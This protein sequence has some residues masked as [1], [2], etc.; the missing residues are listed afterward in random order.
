MSQ[1]KE[2]LKK[3]KNEL[4]T[5]TVAATKDRKLSPKEIKELADTQAKIDIIE[6]VITGGNN[7]TK[8]MK[9][10]YDNIVERYETVKQ[11]NVQI[12]QQREAVEQA[13]EQGNYYEYDQ[14]DI[15][16]AIMLFGKA[17]AAV[18]ATEQLV[19][20]YGKPSINNLDNPVPIYKAMKILLRGMQ[21][22]GKALKQ[23]RLGFPNQQNKAERLIGPWEKKVYALIRKHETE[24]DSAKRTENWNTIQELLKAGDQLKGDL[25]KNESLKDKEKTAA[26]TQI[27]TQQ[28]RL[29]KLAKGLEK[30]MVNFKDGDNEQGNFVPSMKHGLVN[31][32]EKADTTIRQCYRFKQTWSDYIN[33]LCSN[34]NEAL[35]V[36]KTLESNEKELDTEIS[37]AI[38]SFTG[39]LTGNLFSLASGKLATM[40]IKCNEQIVSVGDLLAKT[41]NEFLDTKTKGLLN[42]VNDKAIAFSKF[43]K[44]DFQFI[45]TNDPWKLQA[46]INQ[47]ITVLTEEVIARCDFL[48]GVLDRMHNNF[49]SKQ[50]L[51]K[52]FKGNDKG[53]K[54]FI[55]EMNKKFFALASACSQME[56]EVSRIAKTNSAG[57]QAGPVVQKEFEKLLIFSWITTWRS[58]G[59]LDTLVSSKSIALLKTKGIF[60]DLGLNSDV[61]DNK[62][63][64]AVAGLAEKAGMGSD[65]NMDIRKAVSQMVSK[66]EIKVAAY[67]K[68]SF[69]KKLLGIG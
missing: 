37:A 32:R 67:Q 14:R 41:G 57:E 9:A 34:Y 3:L 5:A 6:S 7:K 33:A 30:Q 60:G 29:K 45:L 50:E 66:S 68:S 10:L 55:D 64:Q 19:N 28:T 42:K 69:W 20:T 40:L 4:K 58:K 23:L 44:K 15:D 53:L 27:E 12:K 35:K 43:Q 48:Y 61:L 65:L 26:I 63:A 16:E 13:H 49:I 8:T 31:L 24:Q 59:E 21:K 51:Q 2:D 11:L 17:K 25:K 1:Y 52:K 38:N 47:K 54:A 56:Q 46:S 36:L 39:L 18:V 22:E 62:L